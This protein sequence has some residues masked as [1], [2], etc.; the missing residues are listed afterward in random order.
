MSKFVKFE[1]RQ[2]G[3]LWVCPATFRSVCVDQDGDL[4]FNGAGFVN[5]PIAGVAAK[6]GIVLEGVNDTPE[7]EPESDMDDAAIKA[8]AKE[9]CRKWG[10]GWVSGPGVTPKWLQSHWI[11]GRAWLTF[12]RRTAIPVGGSADFTWEPGTADYDCTKIA[13]WLWSLGYREISGNNL[14]SA[15]DPKPAP[16]DPVA[17]LV[18]GKTL[19]YERD[20]ESIS[21]GPWNE[22]YVTISP[23]GD[24]YYAAEFRVGRYGRLVLSAPK[25]T[26]VKYAASTANELATSL[27]YRF[28]G[29]VVG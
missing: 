9:I 13:R 4:K 19:C 16:L 23:C 5:A 29:E 25:N 18:D 2:W 6:L 20:P 10:H 24:E 14:K 22:V 28:T 3:T 26:S 11:G 8:F 12:E 17:L 21:R 7:P 27:G 15:P 1:S